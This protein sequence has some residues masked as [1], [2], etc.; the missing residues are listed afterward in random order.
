MVAVAFES[1]KIFD[2][3]G[4]HPQSTDFDIFARH[5]AQVCRSGGG[6]PVPHIA[7]YY[8]A[9]KINFFSIP[10]LLDYESWPSAKSVKMRSATFIALIAAAVAV[11][12]S[13][14]IE[15]RITVKVLA[16]SGVL[17]VQSMA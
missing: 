9:C 2:L 1:L 15:V 17:Q 12:S 6:A 13:D 5:V 4:I 3:A 16:A 8:K 7:K 10:N 11:A 14:S